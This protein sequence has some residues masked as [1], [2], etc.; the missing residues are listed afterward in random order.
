M[1]HPADMTAE[2]P[3]ALR[4]ARQRRAPEGGSGSRQGRSAPKPFDRRRDDMQ[5][6]QD[7]PRH[8]ICRALL[9]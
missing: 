4:R 5:G 9:L 3:G 2:S 7:D 8:C 1:Q 6:F